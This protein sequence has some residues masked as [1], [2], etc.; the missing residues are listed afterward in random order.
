VDAVANQDAAGAE[1]AIKEGAW[2]WWTAGLDL[3][4][5]LAAVLVINRTEGNDGAWLAGALGI[6][7]VLSFFGF[8][9]ATEQMRL[10][11]AGSITVVYL[12]LI[13]HLL[14]IGSLRGEVLS[15]DN[16]KTVFQGF[17]NLVGI[18]VSFY[19]GSSAAVKG[20]ETF[21]KQ[22]TEQAK[23]QAEASRGNPPPG[24]GGGGAAAGGSGV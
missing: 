6:I 19:V 11:I 13:S 12:A 23:I 10:A 17:T 5:W 1:D 8:F 21:Q 20:V 9:L 3:V 22:K 24:G 7:G 2:I 15:D 16:G 14:L 4:I 18:V